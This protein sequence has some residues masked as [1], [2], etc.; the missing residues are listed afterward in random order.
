MEKRTEL[1]DAEGFRA[2]HAMLQA[3]V[4]LLG[5]LERELQAETG[6]TM[7]AYEVL[8]TLRHEPRRY[9]RMQRLAEAVLLSKSGTTR[10]VAQLEELGLVV[11]EIPPDNRRTTLAVL[12]DAG[13]ARIDA[14]MPVLFRLVHE[15]FGRHLAPGEASTLTTVLSRIPAR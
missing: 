12:T 9:C 14:A 3:H 6:L 15:H 13:L 10:V 11:R 2:W 5:V 4:R 8:V 1:V 7:S